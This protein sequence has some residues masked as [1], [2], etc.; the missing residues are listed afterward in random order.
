MAVFMSVG[1]PHSRDLEFMRTFYEV[2][3]GEGNYRTLGPSILP[4]KDTQ[5]KKQL[6][7]RNRQTLKRFARNISRSKIPASVNMAK[8]NWFHQSFLRFSSIW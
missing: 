1:L 6:C 2:T 7:L 3:E 5:T 4:I 8:V